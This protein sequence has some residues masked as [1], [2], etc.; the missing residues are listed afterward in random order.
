MSDGIPLSYEYKT[1]EILYWKSFIFQPDRVNQHQDKQDNE[2]D[3]CNFCFKESMDS[4]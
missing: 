3:C 2:Q 1:S 4:T